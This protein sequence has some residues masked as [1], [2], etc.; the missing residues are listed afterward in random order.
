MERLFTDVWNENGGRPPVSS[1][2]FSFTF[3]HPMVRDRNVQQACTAARVCD[4]CGMRSIIRKSML[5]IPAG[6]LVAKRFL[7][8][9]LLAL[10]IAFGGGCT[11][12]LW[13][14]ETF[15]HF[16]QPAGSTD[17]RLFHSNEQKDILVQYDESK[18]G[19]SNPRPRNYWLEA[20]MSRVNRDRKPRFVSAKAVDRLTP[21]PI[22]RAP[23]RP[24]ELEPTELYASVSAEGDYFILYSGR[25]ELGLFKLPVYSGASQKAKQV[26]LT[27]FAVAIDATLVGAAAAY[28]CAP[29]IFE[30][31]NR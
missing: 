20:N 9:G 7:L 18:G 23:P 24:T 12:I 21:I 17:P 16:Y 3:R 1:G 26:L 11:A 13:D 29:S 27:P 14:R 6:S 30:T 5:I 22:G 19:R 25:E 15:A 28:F 10:Q 31:A 8:A 2:E 4:S